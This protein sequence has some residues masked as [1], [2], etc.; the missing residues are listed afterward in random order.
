M[1]AK[2]RSA[3]CILVA[4]AAEG[5]STCREAGEGEGGNAARAVCVCVCVEK[6][7]SVCVGKVISVC[8]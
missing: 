1:G 6:V 3:A 5:R 7:I 2:R 4:K 8:V